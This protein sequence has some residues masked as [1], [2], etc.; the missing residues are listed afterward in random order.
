[1][2]MDGDLRRGRLEWDG[3]RV[4]VGGAAGTGSRRCYARGLHGAGAVASPHR[5]IRPW[6]SS[7]AELRLMGSDSGDRHARL[8]TVRLDGSRGEGG[9]QIL[10]TGPDALAPDRTTVPHG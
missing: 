5:V 10:R 6:Q 9:G 2:S 7:R 1:M 3:P 8:E 4:V